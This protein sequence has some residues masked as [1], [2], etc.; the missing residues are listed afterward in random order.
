MKVMLQNK[1][2][3]LLLQ[4]PGSWT[5]NLEEAFGFL[6][7]GE[8]IDFAFK[9][10]L[11]DLHVVLW[12]RDLNYSLV[13]PFQKESPEERGGTLRRPNPDDRERPR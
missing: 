12:F 13:I 6:N 5:S 9:H 8:A 2:T 7:S 3:R 4:E 1:T 11:A 10:Q